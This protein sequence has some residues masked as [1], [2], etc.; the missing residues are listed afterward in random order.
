MGAAGGKPN[1][2][3]TSQTMNAIC[4][5][6]WFATASFGG[7]ALNTLGMAITACLGVL[8]YIIYVGSLLYFDRTGENAFPFFAAAAM[9][10]SAGLIF[11]AMGTI[12]MSYSEEQ[13]RG[14]FITVSTNLQGCGSIVGGLITLLINRQSVGLFDS[15]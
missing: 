1:S 15:S 12:A 14:T 11:V 9:G 7:T 2:A 6:I 4:N 5:S 10:V 3:K 13:D 8:G